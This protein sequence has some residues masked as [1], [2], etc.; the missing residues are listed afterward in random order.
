MRF[1]ETPL[2]GAFVLEPEKNR[3]ERGFFA[4]VWCAD[5]LREHG[6]CDSWVQSSISY[7]DAAGTLRGMHF[8]VEPHGETKLVTC[9][10]GA[11]YDVIVDLRIE[12]ATFCRW[13]GIDL[14]AR[15]NLTLY[16]PEGFAHG[17]MTL[18]DE[19]MVQY[20]ISSEY[21]PQSARGVRWDDPA[22][23]ITWPNTPKVMSQRDRELP[24][25]EVSA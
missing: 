13:F 15:N 22:F 5:E 7:N 21:H 9:T 3:D 10:S 4:R 17:F 2:S 8:Q 18:T 12:S 6:L 25:F 23:D 24:D 19:A 1:E 11:V 14:S 20:H 16:V